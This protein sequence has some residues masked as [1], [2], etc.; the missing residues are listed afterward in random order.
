M[1]GI[2]R[3]QCFLMIQ[4]A[5]IPAF[6]IVVAAQ[7]G[8]RR[9]PADTRRAIAND[10]FRELMKRERETRAPGPNSANSEAARAVALR[11]LRE[12]FKSIQ[13]VNNKMMAQAWATE[14]IDYARTS[15]MLGDINERAVRLKNNLS[16]PQPEKIRRQHVTASGLKEFKSAL[17]LMDRS[18]MSFVN[19]PIFRERNV[20]E[21]NLAAQATQD[22]EDVIAFSANLKKIAANLKHAS[23]NR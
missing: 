4:L 3:L 17:M 5:L 16:L 15:S 11:Q 12:D 8:A 20:V 13:D 18:L 2:N 21:V 22:L 19:N 23:E 7:P 6:V 14:G 1:K 10:T 9:T